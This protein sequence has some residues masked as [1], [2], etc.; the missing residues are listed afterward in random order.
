[1]YKVRITV[2]L[3]NISF[4]NTI[5]TSYVNLI[6]HQNSIDRGFSF[7]LLLLKIDLL[8]PIKR[9]SLITKIVRQIN[10]GQAGLVTEQQV[11]MI[12][13]LFVFCSV[14]MTISV[15][16][17]NTRGCFMRLLS[18]KTYVPNTGL[19]STILEWLV[20]VTDVE[21]SAS[22]DW[23]LKT[24][25]WT[26]DVQSLKNWREWRKRWFFPLSF[27]FFF[28]IFSFSPSSRNVFL[29]GESFLQTG[30]FW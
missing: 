13:P 7:F 12:V 25:F 20:S 3:A 16:G 14:R 27:F 29:K 22:I 19:L 9:N 4:T 17:P 2:P 21:T 30:V 8:E 26:I 11:E 15:V 10:I 6:N 23:F 5:F 24:R 1:M 28:F 18:R